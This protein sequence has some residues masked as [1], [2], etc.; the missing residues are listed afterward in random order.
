MHSNYH[1]VNFVH[2]NS[3][4]WSFRFDL[5]NHWIVVAWSWIILLNF[6]SLLSAK[7][8]A[9][10]IIKFVVISTWSCVRC[11][12]LFMIFIIVSLRF[13]KSRCH[14]ARQHRIFSWIVLSWSWIITLSIIEFGTCSHFVCYIAFEWWVCVMSRSWIGILILFMR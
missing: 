12:W 8:D 11:C 6:W 13:S 5:V 14:I 3:G 10:S 1:L 9:K 7:C 2:D 4:T